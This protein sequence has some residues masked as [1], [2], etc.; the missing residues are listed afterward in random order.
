MTLRE[1][2]AREWETQAAAARA[3]GMSQQAIPRWSREGIPP[4]HAVAIERVTQGRITRE[5][6]RPDIFGPIEHAAPQVQETRGQVSENP[7]QVR[8]ETRQVSENPGR[9]AA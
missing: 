7:P 4:K 2:L 6:L 8:P 3:I 9:G 1:I 5:E